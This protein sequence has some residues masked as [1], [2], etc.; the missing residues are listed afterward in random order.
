MAID[1]FLLG[2][3][4]DPLRVATGEIVLERGGDSAGGLFAEHERF[5]VMLTEARQ[6]VQEEGF[7]HW[8]VA[9]PGVWSDWESTRPR[10]GFDAVVG[11]PPWDRLRFQEVEWFAARRPEIAHAATA[12]ERKRLVGALKRADDPLAR[13]HARATARAE[14]AARVARN[15]GAYPMLSR[16]DTNI[17]SLFVERALSLVKPKGV[18]GLLV[19]SGIASDKTASEF[20]KSI[21]GSGRLAALFDF[22]NRG[23]FFPAIDSR[24]KFSAFIAS[25]SQ[26]RFESAKCAF[27]LH[28][29]DEINNP[30]HAFDLSAEDFLRVNPNTGTAPIFRTR[31]D[32]EITT[33]IY[34]RLPVLVDRSE[35]DPQAAW[36][37]RYFTMFH[38]TNDS[39]LFQTRAALEAGGAYRV[40]GN[41]WRRGEEEFLPLY[42][43]KMVQA[44]DHRAASVEV[45]PA[46]LHRPGQP[47]PAS[48]DQHAAP[49]WVPEAQFWIAS[50]AIDLPHPFA[51]FIGFKDVTAP[52]N[53]RSM[54]AAAIP[55]SGV[56]NTF[57][58]LMP[59]HG[60]EAAFTETAC[61]LL[62]NLN[63]VSFDFVARQ[64]IQGQHLNL[65]IVEQL[66]VVPA[67]AYERAFG[68]KTAAEIVREEVLMLT[69]TAND[70]APF[71]R[72][73]G[74]EGTPFAWDAADRLRRRAKLDALYFL[75]YGI[76]DRDDVRYIYSTFPIVEREE[77]AAYGRYISRDY[78]LHYMNA[79]E[80]G[81]PDAEIEL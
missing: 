39:H 67:A 45:D 16:G 32:A 74:Y 1:A 9:F 71:A 44:Y 64:K 54:I 60:Q 51:W 59:E 20:F 55:L 28:S 30:E 31:R 14:A 4:G 8:Q 40:A 72:D 12:A 26:R 52:T 10:G 66:P 35:G 73:M 23:I 33:R 53:M 81:D 79:L 3:F 13:D 56:A 5:P 38:M 36:P 76:T 41:R 69:Y 62:A 65:Y 7:F 11:N 50:T 80:A 61:L 46:R 2:Q 29:V 15:S 77:Q 18:V 27:Y 25:G 57:A 70:M 78:C 6:L 47:V 63:A 58:T 75:L 34:D 49:D 42:E 48:D 68:P 43:G 21:A 24:F 19:P 22:E 17:Y 37:V